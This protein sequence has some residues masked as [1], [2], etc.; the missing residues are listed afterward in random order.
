[1]DAL[2]SLNT[3]PLFPLLGFNLLYGYVMVIFQHFGC[4]KP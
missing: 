2:V 3:I 1:L 4:L